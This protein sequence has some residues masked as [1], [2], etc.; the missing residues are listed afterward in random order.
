MT[1]SVPPLPAI[2]QSLLQGGT[3]QRWIDVALQNL[4]TLLVDQ[5]NCEKKA[6]STAIS[7]LYRNERDTSMMRKLSHL[8]REE[9]RHFE[10]VVKELDRRGLEYAPLGPSRYAK[11]LHSWLRTDSIAMRQFD[12]LLVAAMIEA[13]SCERIFALL[14]CLPQDLQKL[15]VRLYES[16]SRHFFVYYNLAEKLAPD[17]FTEARL[18][19]LRSIEWES[20]NSPDPDMRFHSGI[21][22]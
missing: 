11:R 18:F 16:E 4:P 13:R 10:L 9:L 17:E 15:Y 7:L 12:Q 19:D 14:S 6:A 21:P 3:S 22:N 20:I 5:A 2:V 1:E 8:A